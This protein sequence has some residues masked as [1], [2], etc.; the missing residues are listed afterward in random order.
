MGSPDRISS[1]MTCM[2]KAAARVM[3]LD[4]KI[5]RGPNKEE[6]ILLNEREKNSLTA[7]PPERSRQD[8]RLKIATRSGSGFQARCDVL[9]I[10][11]TLS[12]ST[13]AVSCSGTMLTRSPHD[14]AF[15]DG[16]F[17]FLPFGNSTN[18][19]TTG[20]SLSTTYLVPSGKRL[21]SRDALRT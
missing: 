9:A 13:L 6:R 14:T 5:R 4:H 7:S 8:R 15:L 16:R 19:R 2:T 3:K 1:N 18:R 11:P 20:P 21:G 10:E 17:I 12:D